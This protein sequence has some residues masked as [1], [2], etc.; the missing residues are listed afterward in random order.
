MD[1]LTICAS[2]GMPN[3]VDNCGLP[4]LVEALNG[5]IRETCIYS[6]ER[7][8]KIRLR[9][10]TR[11]LLRQNLGEIRMLELNR[12]LLEDAFP[13]I[14]KVKDIRMPKICGYMANFEDKLTGK[15]FRA[16]WTD[17]ERAEITWQHQQF[18]RARIDGA[19]YPRLPTLFRL[20]LALQAYVDG[21]AMSDIIR[22][23][24]FK[25]R[26]LFQV[27]QCEPIDRKGSLRQMRMA[28]LNPHSV[29]SLRFKNYRRRGV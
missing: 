24:A 27:L 29:A 14:A 22:G 28:S 4:S 18:V 5:I 1:W 2:T 16:V 15:Q 9:R 19:R 12:L 13:E 10:Q 3:E 7:F 20:Q 26:H 17:L 8:E 21:K 11:H 25:R 23:R 6:S